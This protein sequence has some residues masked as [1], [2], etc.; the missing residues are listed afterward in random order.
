MMQLELVHQFVE[1]PEEEEN[2]ED[3]FLLHKDQFIR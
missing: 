1:I 2:K 3:I